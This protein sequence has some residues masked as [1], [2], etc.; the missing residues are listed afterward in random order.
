MRAA[1]VPFLF[2]VSGA[3]AL[4]EEVLWARRFREMLGATAAAAAATLVGVFLGFALGSFAAARVAPRVRRPLRAYGL[5]ELA[6]AAAA[7]LVLPLARGA[8]S[9]L[10][11]LRSALAAT[12]QLAR[13]VE[14]LLA[15]AIVLPP[16][17][18]MG[19]TLPLLAPALSGGGARLLYATNTI[20]AVA[21]ALAVPLLLL[22]RL[23]V[24]GG[25]V[26]VVAVGAAIGVVAWLAGRDVTPSTASIPS[27]A[28]LAAASPSPESSRSESRLSATVAFLSG[29]V[30]LALETAFTRLFAQVH[31]SST[32]AFAAVVAA[33]LASLALATLLASGLLAL[34]IGRTT[35]LAAVWLAGG[36][37][38]AVVP[39][40]FDR[41]TD[42]LT[43]VRGSTDGPDGA[44]GGIAVVALLVLVP[45]V[46]VSGAAL[47]LLLG[48]RRAQADGARLGRTLGWNTLGSLAG[49]LVATFVA[50]PT[51]GTPGLFVAAGGVLVVV[52]TALLLL[53]GSEVSRRARATGGVAALCALAAVAWCAAQRPARVHLDASLEERVV[54]LEEG[55]L[56][57]AAVVG[58]PAGVAIKIDNHYTLGGSLVCADLRRLG[59]LPL[60]LHP[61]PKRVA[62]LG[63]GT[64]IT[65]GASTRH[66][67]IEQVDVVELLPEALDLARRHFASFDLGLFD[68]RRVHLVCDDAR[69]F[70]RGRHGEYDVLVGDLLVPWRAGESAL[71]TREHF[72][73]ARTALAP[74]GLFCQWLPAYQLT[75]E[76]F[77]AIAATFLDV[78]PHATLW[79]GDL[80]PDLPTLGLVG[81]LGDVDPAAFAA[82]V[83]DF[84]VD[85]ESSYLVDPAGPWLFCI[86]ALDRECA[87][88]K[89]ARRH[90][91]D[92]PWLELAGPPSDAPSS[93]SPKLVG[94][95]LDELLRVVAATPLSGT[96][97]E[98]ATAK[99]LAWR[100]AGA[101]LWK[102][103]TLKLAG[104]DAGARALGL[105]TLDTLP[106]P[107]RNAVL[108]GAQ[109]R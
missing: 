109:R 88:F 108:R 20:G 66:A 87:R 90:S 27:V 30:L 53:N 54:E 4:A 41:A 63:L 89:S 9:L 67:S 36:A 8:E 99:E 45:P 57:V 40:A 39:L 48:R 102:A 25:Y 17:F 49:P 59:H 105:A 95:P 32:H 24:G 12:P 56:A 2:L 77:D 94:A 55:P 104:D 29:F 78:F 26:A 58:N 65:A 1:F 19:A 21:G 100:D 11:A 69:T 5:L 70:V 68:D 64:G 60:L 23:G 10:P 79:R 34:P 75:A 47:P 106:A 83:R 82:R 93:R 16:T 18:C 28:S 13:V 76:Q 73:A 50:F 92:T 107:L 103:S 37:L 91:L 42:G 61:A 15:T 43:L 46:A 80:Q 33:F 84:D 14:T 35:A 22:P 71:Y 96:P 101:Q 74:G 81:H 44:L 98:K 72:A 85:R 86:G 97:L 62:F 51:V 31:P 38:V 3:V 52:A 7:L 6:A